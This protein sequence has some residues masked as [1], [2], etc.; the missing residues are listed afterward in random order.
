MNGNSNKLLA[1]IGFLLTGIG[2]VAGGAWGA[3]TFLGNRDTQ[4]FSLEWRVGVIEKN[5]TEE[6]AHQV[7]FQSEISTKL[8]TIKNAVNCVRLLQANRNARCD[9]FP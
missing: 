8:D 4:I 2:A 5:R 6:A 7:Q 9:N 3:A 1:V